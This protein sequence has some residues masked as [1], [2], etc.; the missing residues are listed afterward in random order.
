[1]IGRPLRR[2]AYGSAACEC[3][4]PGLRPGLFSQSYCVIAIDTGG[5]KPEAPPFE[6]RRR[7]DRNW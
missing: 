5:E 3:R 7:R 4:G 2:Q 1:V 6:T